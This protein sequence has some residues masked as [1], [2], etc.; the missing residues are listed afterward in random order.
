MVEKTRSAYMILNG[1]IK[2]WQQKAIMVEVDGCLEH[3]ALIFEALKEVK[4]E[5]RSIL[6]T[7]DYYNRFFSIFC[8]HK[9]LVG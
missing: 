3:S 8:G 9:K 1:Y 4:N 2:R 6:G 5:Y 7:L